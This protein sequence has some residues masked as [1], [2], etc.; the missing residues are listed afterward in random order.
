MTPCEPPPTDGL[1]RGLVSVK[2]V[3]WQHGIVVLLKNQRD[4]WELPG[5]KLQM[6]E[7]FE[8]C[9][10]REFEEELGL[11]VEI[12]PI[13]DAA[14]H[15]SFLD[16]VVLTYGCYPEPF[17]SLHCSEEHSAVGCFRFDQLPSLTMA[18]SYLRSIESWSRDPRSARPR[19]HGH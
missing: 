5:G 15:H 9:L 12:G 19:G 1:Y 6:G 11:R 16:I 13:L 7:S 3:V 14:P 8:A 4:E 18:P 2:G 17:S 10:R